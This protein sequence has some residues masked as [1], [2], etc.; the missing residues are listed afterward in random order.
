MGNMTNSHGAALV[1]ARRSAIG[2]PGLGAQHT[3]PSTMAADAVGARPSN[4]S[5]RRS[6]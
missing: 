6:G 4:R 5:G 1:V 3:K 2:S